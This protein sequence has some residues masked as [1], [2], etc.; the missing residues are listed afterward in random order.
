M[1]RK[2]RVGSIEDDIENNNDE[3]SN[4]IKNQEL[5]NNLKKKLK[6][7]YFP[8][9]QTK[10]IDYVIYYEDEVLDEDPKKI[11]NRSNKKLRLKKEMR[12]R[13]LLQLKNEE[14]FEIYNLI[15]NKNEDE[16]SNYLLLNCSLSRL[17]QEAERMQLV[18]PLKEVFY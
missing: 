4:E 5:A 13:F 12:D 11:N 6:L 2:N 15:K 14:G 9:D 8:N 3:P 10:H 17:M 7:N 18:L 16:T 1:S